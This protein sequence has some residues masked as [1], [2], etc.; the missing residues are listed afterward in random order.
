MSAPNTKSFNNMKQKLKKH[1]KN[2]ESQIEEYRKV[3]CFFKFQILTLQ[4]PSAGAN[5]KKSTGA[6]SDDDVEFED[7]EKDTSATDSDEDDKKP[8]KAQPQQQ[9]QAEKKPTEM[10]PEEVK[11]K[12]KEILAERGKR[13]LKTTFL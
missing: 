2:Y 3:F 1:N 11:A 7:D 10:K 12:L 9:Q 5:K 13:V 6:D 4:N 8:V